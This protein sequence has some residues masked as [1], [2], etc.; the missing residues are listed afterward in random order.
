VTDLANALDNLRVHQQQLDDDGIMVGVSRE[1]LNE[2]IR[3]FGA[4]SLRQSHSTGAVEALREIAAATDADDPESYRCDDREGCL[5][6]VHSIATNALS[7]IEVPVHKDGEAVGLKAAAR[8]ALDDWDRNTCRHE[9]THRGGSIWTIC[10]DCGREWADDRGGF[11][12]YADPQ[13][14]AALRNILDNPPKEAEVTVTEE[15]VELARCVY[16]AKVE[17]YD[18]DFER[19]LSMPDGAWE[20]KYG[21]NMH[22]TSLGQRWA[23]RAALVAA[24]SRKG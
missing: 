14:I 1:A 20:Q 9:T 16:L 12:P 5:D 6:T 13:G 8:Q 10:D 19:V 3:A 21:T 23:M 4:L 15:D 2:V 24:L 17:E 11:V 22:S 18:H 7:T